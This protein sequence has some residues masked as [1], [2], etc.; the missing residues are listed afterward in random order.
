MHTHFGIQET[1]HAPTGCGHA[2]FKK[3]T[4]KCIM[5][6]FRIFIMSRECNKKSTET[7]YWDGS[8]TECMYVYQA[9]VELKC[10]HSVCDSSQ[11]LVSVLFIAVP[12]ILKIQ[13]F[14][15]NTSLVACVNNNGNCSTTFIV[16]T[17][18]AASS[19]AFNNSGMELYKLLKLGSLVV[20]TTWPDKNN[21]I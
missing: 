14:L 3:Y 2:L 11:Q 6:K 12:F 8:Q 13:N 9:K 19:K 4:N 16:S 17:C 10:M 1:R 5:K 21:F 7:S 15:N 20:H 18:W